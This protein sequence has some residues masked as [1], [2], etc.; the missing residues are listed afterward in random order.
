LCT[1]IRT[2]YEQFCWFRLRLSFLCI[3]SGLAFCV[4]SGIAYTF[5]ATVCKTVRPMPSDRCLSCPICLCDRDVG[6]LW[7]KG[8]MDQDKT[9]HGGRPRPWPQCI[10]WRPSSPRPK[11]A[12]QFLSF[13][14]MSI[15]AKRSPISAMPST[16][17]FL[18]CLL[19]LS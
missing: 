13:R 18:C 9:W 16:C 14:P 19:F 4:F 8:W 3:S 12:Q 6:V 11:G 5:W 15:V 1:V 2:P 10:R 17:L 7:P